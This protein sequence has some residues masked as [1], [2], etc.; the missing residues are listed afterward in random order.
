M[1]SGGR[2]YYLTRA[3][4]NISVSETY[5]M[6]QTASKMRMAKKI[7]S[8]GFT[9]ITLLSVS[10]NAYAAPM[11]NEQLQALNQWPNWVA[12]Q[13]GP[14]DDTPLDIEPGSGSPNGAAFPNLDPDKIANAINNWVSKE[15]PDS[16]LKDTGA[17]LVAS[18]K[19]SNVNPFL[20]VAIAHKESGLADP[21]D[22]NVS[23]GNNSFGRMAGA[24]QPSFQ[25][26]RAWYKWSS[27]KASVDYTASEN[28]GISGGG[29]MATYLRNQFGDKL[30]SG[31]LTDLFMEYAPPGDN[32]D[33]AAYISDVKSWIKDLVKLTGSST[34]DTSVDAS[35]GSGSSECCQ[36][37]G[38]VT[39]TGNTPARQAFNYFVTTA[40]YSSKV[41]AGI[42]GNMMTE[43]GGNTEKLDTHAHND[44]SGTHDGIVQWS[45]G[46]WAQLKQY[47]SGKDPYELT[48]Q[49]DYV[50]HELSTS[51][52]TVLEGM[53]GAGSA[54]D[55]ATI[56]NEKFEVSGDTSGHR[57][58]NAQK[59][60]VGTGDGASPTTQDST[61]SGDVESVCGAAADE[62]GGNADM[63]K[64]I[65]VST[66]GK[67]IQ[68][69]SRY[70]CPGRVTKIDSRIAADIAYLVNNYNMC[71][72]DGLAN[73]HL[74]HGAGLG[75]DMRPRSGN[76]KDDWIKTVE[77]AA[78][79]IGWTGDGANDP[80]GS[81]P[82]CS[83]YSGY[84]QCMGSVDSKIP[85]WARW[86]GYNGAVDH[87]DPW[88]VFGGSYAHIHIGWDTPNND[89]VAES[90]IASPR[91]SVYAFPAPV[92]D[93]LKDLIK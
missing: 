88:H 59:I 49:L 84:G 89:G 25:G 10:V 87:G 45:T 19:H 17:V 20:I 93:D 72:D 14:S 27:V 8:S 5:S 16:K 31:S 34:G 54:S 28:Q 77:K 42:V 39:L 18:A 2:K 56:F 12:N 68:L 50:V 66:P 92:P 64:T 32:N 63:K 24:G 71:A 29:D 53:K 85:K 70:S 55:A 46:R 78:R 57:E 21:S 33:T 67:F 15:N 44:I 51:Y 9:L 61:S 90:I 37:G 41:A 7:I 52:K 43:S 60:F 62:T 1:G 38:S 6:H 80:R 13:C 11:T 74:S 47:E 48:T 3:T 26:A 91:A 22:F 23:H 83:N 30:D 65:T 35:G 36:S 76:S 86:I 40:G 73:G 75:I 4:I 82:G 79:D 81:K 58:A 69:P